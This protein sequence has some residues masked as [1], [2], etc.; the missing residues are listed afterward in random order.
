MPH[1]HLM[2]LIICSRPNTE[3]AKPLI[4]RKETSTDKQNAVGQQREADLLKNED[5]L[6]PELAFK[7][8]S[9]S[10]IAARLMQHQRLRLG[11]KGS[12]HKQQQL[13]SSGEN[14]H[15]DWGLSSVSWKSWLAHETSNFTAKTAGNIRSD[16]DRNIFLQLLSGTLSQT[17]GRQQRRS[18]QYLRLG[19]IDLF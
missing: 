10:L 14:K 17:S 15:E 4:P 5:F 12:L 1:N 6:T 19:L 11:V 16:T 8:G 13:Y 18:L 9:F 7:P 2:W 3:P